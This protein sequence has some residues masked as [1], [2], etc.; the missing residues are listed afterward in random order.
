[1][2]SARN[3]CFFE[4]ED[5][6]SRGDTQL[7]NTSRSV[8]RWLACLYLPWLALIALTA[9]DRTEP[10]WDGMPFFY[11]FPLLWILV[12]CLITGVVFLSG[13]LFFSRGP[14]DAAVDAE[15]PLGAEFHFEGFEG[16][17]DL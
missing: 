6:N 17:A 16:E 4:H 14:S 2:L 7:N 5:F 13:G 11:W 3:R 1:V 8:R 10:M 9:Q 15:S 12:G